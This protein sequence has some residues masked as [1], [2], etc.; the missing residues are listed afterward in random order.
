MFNDVSSLYELAALYAMSLANTQAF[1]EGNK[2]TAFASIRAFLKANDLEFDYGP[3][4]EEAAEIMFAINDGRVD[5]E[6]VTEWI[7]SN[8][9]GAE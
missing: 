8:T 3:Y 4:D 2:R 9:V 1:L 5:R 6:E 7:R